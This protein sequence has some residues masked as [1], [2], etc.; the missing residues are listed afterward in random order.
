VLRR[1]APV[2]GGSVINV[3]GWNDRDKEDGH[4]RQYFSSATSYAISNH[5]GERGL[6]DA[7]ATTDFVIDIEQPPAPELRRRFDVVFNHTTLEHVFDLFTAFATLCELSRDV[8]IVVVPFSQEM[9]TTESFGDYWR[10]SPMGL[11][12]LFERNGLTPIFEAANDH[13]SAG[14]Y[15]VAAGARDPDRWRAALGPFEPVTRLGTQIG[16]HPLRRVVP[17]RRP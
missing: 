14:L 13:W 2:F 4:Y 12:R 16:R 7:A 8:V 17:K 1:I 6:A 5:A 11:R 3:S 10:I 15:V 9:H